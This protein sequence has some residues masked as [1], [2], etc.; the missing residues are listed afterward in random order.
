MFSKHNTTII[1]NACN[2][3]IFKKGFLLLELL[4]AFMLLSSALLACAAYHW[5]AIKELQISK[6]HMQAVSYARQALEQLKHDAQHIDSTYVRD[7]YMIE[8]VSTPYSAPEYL[9]TLDGVCVLHK[10]VFMVEAKVSWRDPAACERSV[11]LTSLYIQPGV[12]A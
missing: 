10:N 7:G 1:F 11:V 4:V 12:A 6:C 2:R 8:C 5:H 3:N 9:Q